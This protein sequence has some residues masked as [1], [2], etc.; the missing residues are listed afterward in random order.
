[1][2][3]KNGK[4]TV[5]EQNSYFSHLSGK[6][7]VRKT[8]EAKFDPDFGNEGS[9]AI[10]IKS[11]R[12]SD[13]DT[14]LLAATAQ[15]S[16]ITHLADLYQQK[17][18]INIRTQLKILEKKRAAYRAA[19]HYHR[20]HLIKSHNEDAKKNIEQRS[21]ENPSLGYE[22]SLRSVL[23]DIDLMDGVV[24]DEV[25]IAVANHFKDEMKKATESDNPLDNLIVATQ[26][27][28]YEEALRVKYSDD[29]SEEVE[30]IEEDGCTFVKDPETGKPREGEYGN[31]TQITDWNMEVERDEDGEITKVT[32]QNFS[33]PERNKEGVEEAQEKI[34]EVTGC[35]G[36]PTE[37]GDI[38]TSGQNE[39]GSQES[40]W[41]KEKVEKSIAETMDA[42]GS[43]AATGASTQETRGFK[44]EGDSARKETTQET[45]DRIRADMAIK[46]EEVATIN[47]SGL[48]GVHTND[49]KVL[50]ADQLEPLVKSAPINLLLNQT[51]DIR[52]QAYARVGSPSSRTWRT[53]LG[54]MQVFKRPP[55]TL[56]DVVVM[57]DMSGSM[58]C[59]CQ[60][61]F[62]YEEAAA[63]TC[64]M[65]N[66]HKGRD[67]DQ[68]LIYSF[69]YEGNAGVRRYSHISNGDG[70]A[71]CVVP[72]PGQFTRDRWSNGALAR[73]V[74]TAISNRFSN[75]TKVFGFS[76]GGYRTGAKIAEFPKGLYPN[77]RGYEEFGGGTPTCSAMD[78]MNDLLAG[79]MSRTAGVFIAD[80]TPGSGGMMKDLPI[81]NCDSMHYRHLAESFAK[82]GMR[83]GVVSVGY[84]QFPTDIPN[85]KTAWIKSTD[86]LTNLTPLF[87]H[88]AGR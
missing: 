37:V 40:E 47:A 75:Q 63:I 14:I 87:D 45:L 86:D 41:D 60:K 36:I 44:A 8:G 64:S 35:G 74:V 84:M 62:S 76:S 11:A 25:A 56:G 26:M 38:L 68:P 81:K 69:P 88:L 10:E 78:Y 21:K 67:S 57:T 24:K 50:R 39:S 32:E 9:D 53:R 6:R 83:F 73:E 42:Y 48:Y 12:G 17:I 30:W 2:P 52:G 79:S 80:G 70:T 34:E 82:R 15:R 43:T 1:M 28:R 58:G 31:K 71:T 65:V 54:D 72:K 20:P 23:Y 3:K 61:C 19:G 18:R 27:A 5:N 51:R 49:I 13:L 55:D 59:G 4:T 46:S 33:S 7:A 77:H 29:D 22:D 66:M 85:A 16:D